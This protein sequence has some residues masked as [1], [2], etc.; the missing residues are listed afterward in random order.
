MTNTNLVESDIPIVSRLSDYI[1][2][3]H[4]CFFTVEGQAAVESLGGL[5]GEVVC[6]CSGCGWRY[7]QHEG[8]D[9]VIAFWSTPRH[10]SVLLLISQLLDCFSSKR[11]LMLRALNL[12]TCYADIANTEA[13]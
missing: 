6:A 3:N 8:H 1:I 10:S 13:H 11:W 9:C 2:S 12:A 5:H 4:N 7:S